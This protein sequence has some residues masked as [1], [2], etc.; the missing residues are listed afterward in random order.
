MSGTLIT[1]S[2]L[3]GDVKKKWS[4]FPF[5]IGKFSLK[6]AT[7]DKSMLTLMVTQIDIC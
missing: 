5:M 6:E 4:N 3:T 1:L 2:Y 7:K